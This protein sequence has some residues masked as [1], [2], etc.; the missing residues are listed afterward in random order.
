MAVCAESYGLRGLWDTYT[1]IAVI[2]LVESDPLN[3]LIIACRTK[4]A[5]TMLAVMIRIPE[6]KLQSPAL[7]SESIVTSYDFD[8]YIMIN[9]TCF[10]RSSD[11][12]KDGQHIDGR[13]LAKHFPWVTYFGVE[14]IPSDFLLEVNSL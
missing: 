3:A 10:E 9:R 1:A 6:K 11:I 14:K 4:D 2:E 8:K 5:R 12:L 13:E 7:W